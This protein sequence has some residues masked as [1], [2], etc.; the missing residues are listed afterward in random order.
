MPS[1]G[2]EEEAVTDHGGLP[3]KRVLVVEDNEVN[4]KVVTIMLEKAGIIVEAAQNGGVAVEMFEAGST[5]DLVIMDLQMPEMNG[6][7]TA[8]YIRKKLELDIPIV[9]MTASALRNEKMKCFG[10]G[11]NEYLPKWK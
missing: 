8:A 5:F 1:E 7:Q 2:A 11:M 3:G 4:L 9:A 6:F 10:L